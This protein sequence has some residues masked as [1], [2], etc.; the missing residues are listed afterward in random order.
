VFA[1]AHTFLKSVVS[2]LTKTQCQIT[3]SSLV[4]QTVTFILLLSWKETHSYRFAFYGGSRVQIF[5]LLKNNFLEVCGQGQGHCCRDS[6]L[7]L[8]RE[9]GTCFSEVKLKIESYFDHDAAPHRYFYLL[10]QLRVSA[11]YASMKSLMQSSL[12]L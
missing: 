6:K 7:T 4:F 3:A 2:H 5:F 12:V 9:C 8:S 11:A 1:T 10:A